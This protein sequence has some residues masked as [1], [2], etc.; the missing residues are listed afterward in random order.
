MRH[1][2][3]IALAIFGSYF[4]VILVLFVAIVRIIPWANTRTSTQKG[5]VRLFAGLAL[6]SFAHTWYCMSTTSVG[7]HG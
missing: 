7:V 1:D 3:L 5:R 4:S 2:Q 6:A